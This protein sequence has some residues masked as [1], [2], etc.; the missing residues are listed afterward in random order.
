M[1][2]ITQRQQAVTPRQQ[3]VTP[4]QQAVT[5]RQQAVTQKQSGLTQKQSGVNQ[6]Q[7]GVNQRKTGGPNQSVLTVSSYNSDKPEDPIRIANIYRI[8]TD[9]ADL[10]N[11]TDAELSQEIMDVTDFILKG[12]TM[13]NFLP[14]KYF[15]KDEIT[16]IFAVEGKL[17]EEAKS[18]ILTKY[19]LIPTEAFQEQTL[20]SQS[21]LKVSA[22]NSALSVQDPQVVDPNI[23]TLPVS[24]S[25]QSVQVPDS[26]LEVLNPAL[27]VS[28]SN[29]EVSDLILQDS[30]S[31]PTLSDTKVQILSSFHSLPS[32]TTSLH[33][34]DVNK[35]GYRRR[36]TNRRK[37]RKTKRRNTKRRRSHTKKR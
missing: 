16:L 3:A 34:N 8:L 31:T 18:K 14:H 21:E 33:D 11:D 37:N 25:N 13:S 32:S 2:P 36:K 29:Q 26:P 35:G 15:S 19:K 28:D 17:S 27:T 6:R 4:R 24:D 9:G 1:K 10:D 23:V 22:S 5:P 30:S 12:Y 7:S 20:P